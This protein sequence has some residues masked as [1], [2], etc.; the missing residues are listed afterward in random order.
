MKAAS[1]LQLAK[2]SHSTLK[3][4][5][6]SSKSSLFDEPATSS[7]NLQKFASFMRSGSNLEQAASVDQSGVTM[8][9]LILSGVSNIDDECYEYMKKSQD[10]QTMRGRALIPDPRTPKGMQSHSNFAK[11]DPE[12]EGR[13]RRSTPW[14]QRQLETMVQNYW[15]SHA[16]RPRNWPSIARVQAE[17][18]KFHQDYVESA[19]IDKGKGPL[20]SAAMCFVVVSPFKVGIRR[21]PTLDES[22][23]T[24]DT[25]SPGQVI[26]ARSVVVI[27]EVRFIKLCRGGWVFEWMDD[28]KVMA[29]MTEVEI[30]L[31]WYRVACSEFVEVRQ[32]PM[33][34]KYCLSGWVMSPSEV[35]VASLRCQVHDCEFL[36]LAD[37]RGW[38]FVYKLP[39]ADS[40]TGVLDLRIDPEV[41]M[42]P[43]EEQMPMEM[44]EQVDPQCKTDSIEIG[45]WRYEVLEKPLV[46]LGTTLNGTVLQAGDSIT[47]DMRTRANG[48]KLMETSGGFQVTSR[49]WL[50]LSDG[51]GWIPKTDSN[52]KP[53]V[54]FTGTAM[55]RSNERGPTRDVAEPA[56]AELGIV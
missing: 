46:A 40:E 26:V 45:H 15:K 12:Y 22:E 17:Q 4:G 1:K 24:G 34:G 38:V 10:H 13:S 32:V 33:H 2:L 16:T 20:E 48:S 51:K 11:Q 8:T 6:S 56:F 29:E 21:T 37:G 49:V 14:E 47:V 9:D 31:R 44:E 25:L 41:V 52:G 42:V 18:L 30:G 5:A 19:T 53:T 54:R 35:C 7:P 50:R 28:L 43:C 55:G 23:K 27:S 39:P 3:L 36:Q